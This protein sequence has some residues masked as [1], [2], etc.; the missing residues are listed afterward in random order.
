MDYYK[1]LEKRKQ[2]MNI[3]TRQKNCKYKLATSYHLCKNRVLSKAA[4]IMHKTFS[5]MVQL[6]ELAL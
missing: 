4:E 2:G 3:I 1:P 6:G 5:L